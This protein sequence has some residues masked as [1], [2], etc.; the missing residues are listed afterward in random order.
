[1]G[2]PGYLMNFFQYYAQLGEN[3]HKVSPEN[4]AISVKCT[5][6]L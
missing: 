5:E 2:M 4:I 3:L 1:M 6:I